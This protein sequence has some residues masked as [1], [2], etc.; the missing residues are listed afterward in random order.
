LHLVA[1]IK[2]VVIAFVVW[3]HHL[4]IK[5]FSPSNKLVFAIVINN[6]LP[7]PCTSF[8]IAIS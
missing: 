4:R 3:F 8:L 1:G 5:N 7:K 2:I 6:A